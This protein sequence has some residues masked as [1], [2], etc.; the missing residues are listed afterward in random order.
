MKRLYVP[1]KDSSTDIPSLP[2]PLGVIGR[3]FRTTWANMIAQGPFP[4]PR[5]YHQ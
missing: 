2:L 4:S 5:L 3:A 1:T